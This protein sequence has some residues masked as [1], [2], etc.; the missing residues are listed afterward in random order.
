MQHKESPVK[1][2]VTS[3]Y[4]L[5]DRKRGNRQVNMT[6]VKKIMRD[7]RHGVNL[8]PDFPILVAPGSKLEVLD[9]QHRLEA[10]RQT[11]SPI[12]YIIRQEEL[13]LH[14]MARFNSLQDKWKPADF[15]ACYI[16]KGSTDYKKL[17]N[18]LDQYDVPVSI[19]LNLLYYGVTGSEGGTKDG[20]QDLFRKGEFKCLH[21]R[22]ACDIMDSCKQFSDFGGWNTRPFIIAIS[23]ILKADLCDFDE[24]VEK[25]KK[26]PRMMDY[27]SST[28]DYLLN[29]EQIYNK[30]MHKRR[31]IYS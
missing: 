30:G 4:R 21:W 17:S 7:I 1:V 2:Y 3:D 13:A 12:Y 6:K 23:R 16:E 11:K 5:F 22:Q 27:H 10:A 28:K 19:A 9:G 24:L 26:D 18:F 20:M 8:L 31:T 14:T 15:I 25:F 29:L